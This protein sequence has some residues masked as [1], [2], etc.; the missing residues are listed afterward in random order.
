MRKLFGVLL[1]TALAVSFAGAAQAVLFN[2]TGQSLVQIATLDPVVLNANFEATVNASGGTGHL[3]SFALPASPFA[4]AGLVVPVTDPAAAPIGGVQVTVHNA[5]GT[6]SEN[7]NFGGT[8]PLAGTAKVCLFGPCSAAVQNLNVPLSN[9]GQGGSSFVNNA[10]KITVI[11]APWTTGTAQI[12]TVTQMGLV[13]GPASATSSTAN[14]SGVANLVTPIFVSTNISASAVVPAFG[15]LNL[16]FGEVVP[17]PG[18]A[19]LLGSGI[20]GLVLYGRSRRSS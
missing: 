4:T 1:G 6:F 8:A 13:H 17:E 10:V 2:M 12:G 11:G 16:H 5:A 15:F 9:V 18:T 7:T 14:P 19:L 20:A 3:N